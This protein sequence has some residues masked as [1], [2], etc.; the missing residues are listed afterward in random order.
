MGRLGRLPWQRSA[1]V[2]LVILESLR[3]LITRFRSLDMMHWPLTVQIWGVFVES[4]AV[5]PVRAVFDA[6]SG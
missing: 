1:A 5:D 3:M 4:H 2:T 6:P